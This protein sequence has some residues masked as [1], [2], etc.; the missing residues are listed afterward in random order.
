MPKAA[1]DIA[2]K[3]CRYGWN[4]SWD[5]QNQLETET[6]ARKVDSLGDQVIGQIIKTLQGLRFGVVSIVV[7]DGVVVQIERT[8]KHRLTR[9]QQ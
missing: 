6:T 3:A 2:T 1:F 7:Q 5:M 9:P 8:E 4:R